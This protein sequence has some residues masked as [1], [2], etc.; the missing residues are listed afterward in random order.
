MTDLADT[1]LVIA[2]AKHDDALHQ[3]AVDHVAQHPDLTVSLSVGLELLLIA[4]RHAL[5]AVDLIGFA[6]HHFEVEHAWALLSAAHAL[7][8]GELT[9]SFDA[10][11]CALARVNGGRLHTADQELLA[12]AFPTV[13]F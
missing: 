8:E 5:S 9:T 12:S 13:A 3:R 4:Q 2:L 1:N 6:M 10:V 7:D 11:L